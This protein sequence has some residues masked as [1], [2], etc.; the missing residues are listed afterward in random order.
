M[1]IIK[2]QLVN[3][4]EEILYESKSL[5]DMYLYCKVRYNPEQDEDWFVNEL[6]DDEY[7][8][9]TNVAF[10]LDMYPTESTL[11]DTISDMPLR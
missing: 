9:C 8:D 1:G 4:K 5:S 2:F 7:F 10:L 11:P 6:E 3:D